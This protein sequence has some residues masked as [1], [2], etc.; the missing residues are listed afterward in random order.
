MSI[1][2]QEAR[3]KLDILEKLA[4]NP[5][6]IMTDLFSEGV[7]GSNFLYQV[8]VNGKYILDYLVE[9]LRTLHVFDGTLPKFQSYDLNIYVPALKHGEYKQFQPE[10]KIMK[11]NVDR[12]TYRLCDKDIQKYSDVMSKV[13]EL[14]TCELSDFWKKYE[15]FTFKNRVKNAFKSL[16][17]D[18]KLH[19]RLWD[20][21]FTLIVS[22]KKVDVAL[23]REREKVNSKNEYN[24]KYYNERID[25]QNYY[26]ENAP[27]H[28]TLIHSK[29]NEIVDYLTCLGY[30]EDNEM[31]EY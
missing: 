21:V 27:N 15:D 8:N 1:E 14:E 4:S 16:T 23:D 20:F 26:M 7:S 11:V 12:R 18:K 3:K 22:K 19:I 6:L 13:Y 5:E 31:S 29:Q 25:L 17:T 9:Y 24:Q 2:L 30:Q 28:I 10:D